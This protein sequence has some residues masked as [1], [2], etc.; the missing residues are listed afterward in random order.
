MADRLVKTGELAKEIGVKPSTV[1]GYVASGRLVPDR[2][3]PGNQALFY[4]EKAKHIL[5]LPNRGFPQ[6]TGNMTMVDEIPSEFADVLA[7]E[8]RHAETLIAGYSAPARAEFDGGWLG[9]ERDPLP[10]YQLTSTHTILL[11][12]ATL[13][14]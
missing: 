4:A 7:G 6:D 2:R 8:P 10:D 3:T 1:R 5:G 12:R 14:G 9:G 11:D 13:E